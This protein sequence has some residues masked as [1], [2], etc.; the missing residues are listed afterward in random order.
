MFTVI[1]LADKAGA[2]PRRTRSAFGCGTS[3]A[4]TNMMWGSGYPHSEWTFPES[5]KIRAEIL[6][7][8]L[9]DE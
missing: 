9:E 5:R 6:A 3:S 7:G 8:V 1:T 2:I 4:S